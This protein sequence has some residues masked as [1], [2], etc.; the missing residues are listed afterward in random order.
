[1]AWELLLCQSLARCSEG[2]LPATLVHHLW[3]KDVFSRSPSYGS[4]ILPV[5]A[6]GHHY[7]EEELGIMLHGGVSPHGQ[8]LVTGIREHFVDG[9]R[10]TWQP[11]NPASPKLLR[12]TLSG[13]PSTGVSL[14]YLPLARYL[15]PSHKV[16]KP[17][18]SP[19][20]YGSSEQRRRLQRGTSYPDRGLCALLSRRSFQARSLASFPSCA[21]GLS[22]SPSSRPFTVYSATRSLRQHRLLAPTSTTLFRRPSSVPLGRQP[23]DNST[24]LL[25]E[26]FSLNGLRTKPKRL[27][28]RCLTA[29]PAL[30]SRY[31]QGVT[32]GTRRTGPVAG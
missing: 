31:S 27:L 20:R 29:A 3:V 10:V 32:P 17:L 2:S 16:R 24:R 28:R 8:L 12:P 15:A 22:G 9:L 18:T 19:S 11:P 30:S 4:K 26:R 25:A 23:G 6:S 1:V 13:P 21:T 14:H 5:S 7:E